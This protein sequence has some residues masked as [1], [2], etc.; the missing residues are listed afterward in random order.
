MSTSVESLRKEKKEW[1]GAKEAIYV[2]IVE[3]PE[4]STVEL[5]IIHICIL[6]HLYVNDRLFET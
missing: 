6:R 4:K 2:E 1:E 5:M 3:N